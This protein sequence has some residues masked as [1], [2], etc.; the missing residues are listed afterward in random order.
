MINLLRY[1]DQIAESLDGKAFFEHA[2]YT[3]YDEFSDEKW[4]YPKELDDIKTMIKQEKRV[5]EWLKEDDGAEDKITTNFE[6]YFN[7]IKSKLKN[8]NTDLSDCFWEVF[9]E[10]IDSYLE[11]HPMALNIN[12]DEDEEI[13]DNEEGYRRDDDENLLMWLC[14]IA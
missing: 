9:Q 12:D 3:V 6:K 2:L 14:A 1:K 5:L 13:Y 8:E 7:E 10:H 11:K 4:I